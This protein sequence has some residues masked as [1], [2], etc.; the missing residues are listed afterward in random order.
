MEPLVGS[1]WSDCKRD[2]KCENPP[3]FEKKELLEN[4][5]LRDDYEECMEKKGNALTPKKKLISFID[6]ERIF[7]DSCA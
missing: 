1:F 4:Q 3:F 2:N 6:L 7:L 5:I